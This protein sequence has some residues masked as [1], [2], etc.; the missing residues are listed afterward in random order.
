VLVLLNSGQTG[1]ERGVLRAARHF[2]LLVAGFMTIDGHDEL[3][4]VPD[5]VAESLLRSG[6]R[7]PRRAQAANIKLASAVIVAVPDARQHRAFTGMASVITAA[8]AERIPSLICDESNIDALS[9]WLQDVPRTPGATRI[10]ITGPR[11]TRWT[12]GERMGRIIVASIAATT[13]VLMT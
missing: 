8:R 5:D 1:V 4:R 13:D 11:G 2:G 7:G 9:G 6:E 3:G 10:Y 12:E